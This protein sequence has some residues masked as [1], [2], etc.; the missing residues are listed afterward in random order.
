MREP[1]NAE[2]SFYMPKNMPNKS[3]GIIACRTVARNLVEDCQPVGDD[4]RGSGIARA[5]VNAAWQ[6]KVRPPR[7]NGKPE[8]G[9]WVSIRIDFSER[10]KDD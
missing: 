7:I 8:I 1:T 6:F 4:P 2:L 10:G 3:W 5:L 9:S